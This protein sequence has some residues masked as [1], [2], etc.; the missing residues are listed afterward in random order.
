MVAPPDINRP[1]LYTVR[2]E[3]VVNPSLALIE[4]PLM[5]PV[6][7]VKPVSEFRPPNTT[8]TPSVT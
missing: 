8:D 1:V 3:A 4:T 6:N 7:T 2:P 5:P